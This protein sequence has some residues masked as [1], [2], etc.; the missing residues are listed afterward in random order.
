MQIV[1]NG[2][3]IMNPDPYPDDLIGVHP[4]RLDHALLTTPDTNESLHF[5]RDV[6]GFRLTE[7]VV[8]PDGTPIA[9]WLERSHTPHDLALI[10]G[11]TNSPAP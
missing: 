4:P 9:V 3:P 5:W 1:G 8:T 10:P 11:N 6:L 2:L 7:Q